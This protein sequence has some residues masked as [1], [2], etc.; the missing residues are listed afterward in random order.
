MSFKNMYTPEYR[1]TAGQLYLCGED[2]RAAFKVISENPQGS[3]RIWAK[4]LGWRHSRVARFLDAVERYE[5]GTVERLGGQRGT[6]VHFH[7]RVESEI[8]SEYTRPA[9]PH[10]GIR[11]RNELS[12]RMRFAVFQRDKFTCVYC[13]AKG[14]GVRLTVDHVHPV[15]L[16]GSDDMENL[17]TA[18]SECNAGKGAWP[19]TV[20]TVPTSDT[21]S[22][23]H[24]TLP[25]RDLSPPATVP[26]A[27]PA[28]RD[29]GTPLGST[30]VSGVTGPSDRTAKRR[31]VS[32]NAGEAV[33]WSSIAVRM[34]PVM[35]E[36]FARLLGDAYREIL[37]DNRG[38]HRAG[39]QLEAAH[40]DPDWCEQRLRLLCRT[41]NPSKHGGGQAPRT[42]AYF[43]GGL[44]RDWGQYSLPLL[45]RV[46][47]PAP[48]PVPPAG[49][50]RAEE[51]LPDPAP[52]SDPTRW[53]REI[54]LER[55]DL[56]RI[57]A[58]D[59]RRAIGG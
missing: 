12:P 21:V 42:L 24:N 46:D 25:Q 28:S 16:G 8:P 19:L 47:T 37:P 6:I 2:Q 18:C 56:S 27:V 33:P 15:A 41:F 36:E 51:Q 49:P 17:A 23:I 10:A 29:S 59:I 57:G 52:A 1:R 14:E 43:V 54:S 48:T 26:P 38:S 40:V 58:E 30:G 34:I 11:S 44:I 31:S 45:A 5:L 20:S 39:H 7:E 9:H 22:A 55:K 3:L 32:H 53:R 4:L 13:G 50:P 35:N